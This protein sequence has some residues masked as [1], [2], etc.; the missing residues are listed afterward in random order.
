MGASADARVDQWERQLFAFRATEAA[1]PECPTSRTLASGYIAHS[2]CSHDFSSDP[3]V[4][5]PFANP[6]NIRLDDERQGKLIAGRKAYGMSEVFDHQHEGNT[7][8]QALEVEFLAPKAG[9][10]WLRIKPLHELYA[11]SCTYIWDP[12]SRMLAWLEEIAEGS[13]AATWHIDQEGSLSRLQFYGGDRTIDDKSDYLLHVQMDS[14]G[15]ARVRGAMIERRQLIESFYWSYRAMTQRPD[16]IPRE[17][18]AHPDYRSVHDIEDDEE[19]LR[20]NA[21]FPYGGASLRAL[22][23]ERLEAYLT[24]AGATARKS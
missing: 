4:R 15:I 19:Y 6:A 3:I 12:F 8:L 23:S 11:I 9:W 18:E 22:T 2:L 1:V 13:S 20:E 21:K 10:I 17:W 16:Y 24:E 5:P 14:R 7:P